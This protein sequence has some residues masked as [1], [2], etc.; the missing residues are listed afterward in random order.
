MAGPDQQD[1]PAMALVGKPAPDFKLEGL[2]GKEVHLADLKG[3]VVVLD[4]WATWCGPC[5]QSMPHLDELYKAESPKGLKV[6]AVNQ[7]EDKDTVQGFLKSR[8]LTVP[9]LLDKDGQ[10]GQ[11][12]EAN[13]IPQ[14]VIVGKDGKV[15]KVF[16]GYG[17]DTGDQIRKEVEAAMK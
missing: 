11:A 17:M 14:T 5:V 9:A 3:S 10:V 1:A 6:F 4:F 2:D 8:N 12:Y 13:A 16:I 7:E 15:R